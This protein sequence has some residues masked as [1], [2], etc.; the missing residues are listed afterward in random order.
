MQRFKGFGH[1]TWQ[2]GIELAKMAGTKSFALFHHAPSRTDEQLRQMEKDAKIA[3]P[4]AFAA[5]DNQVVEI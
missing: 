2:H 1:S 5:R 4:G 3:F